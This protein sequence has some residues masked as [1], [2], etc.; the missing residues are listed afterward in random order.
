[1][2]APAVSQDLRV[3]LRQHHNTTLIEQSSP[4]APG[5]SLVVSVSMSTDFLGLNRIEQG[6]ESG[7]VQPDQRVEPIM[8]IVAGGQSTRLG[9]VG[10]VGASKWQ[11]GLVNHME[12]RAMPSPKTS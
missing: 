12:R 2:S 11:L 1:V 10:F 9:N 6:L 4:V 5:P 8:E 3:L 7:Q